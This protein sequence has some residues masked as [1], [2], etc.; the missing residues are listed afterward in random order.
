MP[1][2]VLETLLE[3]ARWAA[4]GGNL[5]PWRYLVFNSRGPEARERARDCLEESNQVWARHAPV[6]LLAVAEENRPSGRPNP[7]ALH[8]VGLANAQLLLQAIALGM[9]CRPMGGFDAA[10][11]REAFGIPDG[12]RPVAMIAIGYPGSVEAL[13]A[14]L[15][16]QKTAPRQRR[17]LEAT[18]FLG[19]WRAV[20]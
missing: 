9:H 15:A 3:A 12:F 18:A 11:A 4:S 17:P 10:R 7:T 8:D 14:R 2:E 1:V 13:P 5:Q 20:A 19:A 16:D 6:L